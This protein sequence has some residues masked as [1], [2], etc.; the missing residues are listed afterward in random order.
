MSWDLAALAHW[1]DIQR[2]V[3]AIRDHVGPQAGGS[4]AME[5]INEYMRGVSEAAR[6]DLKLDEADR[7]ALAKHLAESL[8]PLAHTE[9]R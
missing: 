9:D 3:I 6:R 8:R 1:D 7:K 4:K 5:V 2:Q